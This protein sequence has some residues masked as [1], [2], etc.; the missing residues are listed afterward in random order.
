MYHFEHGTSSKFGYKY[1][2]LDLTAIPK[3]LYNQA[4]RGKPDP[5]DSAAGYDAIYQAGKIR[6]P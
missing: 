4:T 2:A 3:D 5:F 1:F 6:C